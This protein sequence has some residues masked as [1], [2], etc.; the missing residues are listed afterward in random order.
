MTQKPN[1]QA[2]LKAALEVTLAITESIRELGE[3][4]AGHLYAPL[5]GLMS[6]ATF[7]S[8]LRT[9]KNAGLVSESPAHLLTWIGPKLA[10]RS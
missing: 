5:M 7:E 6:L 9:L 4:P 10:V 3:I 2:A 1:T 8:I